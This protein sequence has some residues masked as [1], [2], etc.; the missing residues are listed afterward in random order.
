MSIFTGSAV[1]IITPFNADGSI[2]YDA[3]K[4][5]VETQI[6]AGTSAIAVA[7]TTG[8]AST[9]DDAEQ[10]KLIKYCVDIVNRRY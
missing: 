10:I 1:A 6:A 7:C 9:I 2:N 4:N 8:E 5:M 3:F